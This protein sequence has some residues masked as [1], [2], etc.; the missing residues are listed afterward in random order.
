MG[1]DAFA[2]EWFQDIVT[3]AGADGQMMEDVAFEK[4]CAAVVEAGEMVT[5]DRVAYQG[6]PGS[7]V[8]VDGYGGDPLDDAVG[9]LGLIILDFDPSLSA[10]RLTNTDLGVLFKRVTNFLRHA[11]DSKWRNA[12]EETS[13]AFGLADLIAARWSKVSRVR[14]LVVSNRQLSERVSDRETET[15]EGRPVAFGVWDLQRLYRFA[16]VGRGHEDVDVDLTG[17]FGGPLT[18]LRADQAS[19]DFESYLA[20][21][22]GETLA[23]IYDRFGARLLEQNVRV[24]LQARGKVN[25][26]IRNTLENEP[27]RFFAY[28]NGITAT[29]ES[30]DI[31]RDNGLLR[32]CGMKN[33]QI[34]NGGQTTASLHVAYRGRPGHKGTE[35]DLSRT[36]VQV[37]LTVVDRERA[38]KLVPKISEYA[39]TQNRVSAADFF[40][41]HP[42]HVRLE[43]FSRRMYAPSPDGTFQQSK[44]FYE[45][46]RGQYAD[47]RAQFATTPQRKKFDL[48]NPRRQLFSKTDLARFWAVWEGRPHVVSLGAQKNFA[49]FG[50]RVDRAWEKDKDQ[51]GEAWFREVV[52]KAITFRRTERIVSAQNWYQGGYRANIV[53]YAIAKLAH[54]VR[55]SR[56]AVDFDAIWQRQALTEAMEEALALVAY[57]VHEVLVAPPEGMRNVTEWAKKQACWQRVQSGKVDW[58]GAFLAELVSA[59]DRAGAARRAK[60]SQRVLNGVE[61]QIAVVNAGAGFW[62]NALQWGKDRGLLTPKETGVIQVATRL[63][64]EMPSDKQSVLILETFNRL[65]SEG[66]AM[67]LPDSRP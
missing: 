42:F 14:L 39:N 33:F 53:A 3:A 31:E 18:V 1:L 15:L 25:R 17:D 56:S 4:L 63:P 5:A 16:E 62:R 28:N 32:L 67:D 7:G 30:V 37:K 52:A 36:S 23:A 51:F 29:A 11:L 59:E 8:R 57:E 34:V 26:G 55:E 13:P 22:P 50:G 47:A 58:P 19:D 66:Y 20:V 9:T 41:N 48:E 60:R 65:R 49:D 43:T 21:I 46:A 44:W 61:A 27:S 12:L 40:S 6:P 54:D 64:G 35:V 38:A 45:R 2:E 10:N 24:F